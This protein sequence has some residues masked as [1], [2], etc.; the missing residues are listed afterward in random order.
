MSMLRYPLLLVL[1][2]SLNTAADE[3]PG[4]G[5]PVSASE[6]ESL[7]YTVEP[8]G[9]GLPSGAGSAVEG[10]VVYQN[11]CFACHGKNGEDGINDRLA[12]GHGSLTTARPVKTVG[13]FWPYATTIFDYV[14]RAMPFQ[15][16][17]V[18]SN[19]EL[20]AVTAYLLFINDV[21]D[22]DEIMNA[23][24]LPA[25]SMPNSDKFVWDFVPSH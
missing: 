20:Y 13:S 6:L 23:A 3:M 9:E 15:T 19:D 25:V 4:L 8:D 12:G 10:A 17:G 5:E 24:S 16:P 14:R 21:I 1:F 11:H 2:L 22:Q 7:D 18:L